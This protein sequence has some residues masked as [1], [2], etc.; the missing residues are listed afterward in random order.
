MARRT[1]EIGLNRAR[2]GTR[3]PHTTEWLGAITEL[4]VALG[5]TVRTR[6]PPAVSQA[7]FPIAPLDYPYMTPAAIVEEETAILQYF[8]IG[9]AA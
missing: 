6:L 1:G 2:S 4:T 5:P 8:P 7:N 9:H 3:Y